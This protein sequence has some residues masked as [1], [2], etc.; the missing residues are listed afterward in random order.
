MLLSIKISN[1]EEEALAIAL[2]L[3]LH[4]VMNPINDIG[5]QKT[6]AK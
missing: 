1:E 2:M 5:F 6:I 4:D 3:R